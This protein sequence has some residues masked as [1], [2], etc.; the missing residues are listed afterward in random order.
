M[1][2][3]VCRVNGS[4]IKWTICS[5]EKGRTTRYWICQG[6]CKVEEGSGGVGHSVTTAENPQT[7]Q[8]LDHCRLWQFGAVVH[9]SHHQQNVGDEWFL[10][11]GPGENSIALAAMC[12][13]NEDRHG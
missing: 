6:K 13:G 2:S 4:A 9:E 8:A 1:K 11:V 10:W 5:D 3:F 12:K 7:F